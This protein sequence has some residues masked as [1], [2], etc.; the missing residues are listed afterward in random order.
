M[1]KDTTGKI[2]FVDYFGNAQ[3]NEYLHHNGT[4]WRK[5]STRTAIIVHP[6]R[7][8]GAWF[9]FGQKEIVERHY[10]PNRVKLSKES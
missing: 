2:W 8:S 6:K 10:L 5:R 3:V 1:R 9:Y 7:H 4:L